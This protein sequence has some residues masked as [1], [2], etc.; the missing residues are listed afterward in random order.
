MPA[1][2]DSSSQVQMDGERCHQLLLGEPA[3]QASEVDA[4]GAHLVGLQAEHGRRQVAGKAVVCRSCAEVVCR[5]CACLLGPRSAA[6]RQARTAGLGT[7]APQKERWLRKTRTW[8]RRRRR[9]TRTCCPSCAPSIVPNQLGGDDRDGGR[10]VQ[11]GGG[12]GD[13]ARDDIR[14]RLRHTHAL[15]CCPAHPVPGRGSRLP[16]WSRPKKN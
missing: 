9:R 8:W 3:D 7:D 15:S 14:R 10:V 6:P 2:A 11:G 5:S 16:L 1:L 13:R 12:Q 4:A